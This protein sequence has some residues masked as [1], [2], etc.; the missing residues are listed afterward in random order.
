MK[1]LSKFSEVFLKG[2]LFCLAPRDW[3]VGCLGNIREEMKGQLSIVV[4]LRKSFQGD[5]KD[6]IVV[7]LLGVLSD[8]PK[9]V[10]E[11]F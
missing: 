3:G 11:G 7:D 10:L 6:P 1:F 2:G 5:F 8:P 9:K 4:C